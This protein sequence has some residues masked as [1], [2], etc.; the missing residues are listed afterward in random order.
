MHVIDDEMQ[1]VGAPSTLRA[2]WRLVKQWLDP[3]TLSKISILSPADMQQQQLLKYMP[4]TSIPREYGGTLDWKW[5]DKPLLDE[6]ARELAG[7]LYTH[8]K[9]AGG[10]GDFIEG[11]IIYSEGAIEVVGTVQRRRRED[12]I[13]TNV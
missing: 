6:P 8:H 7:G 5:G 1:I 9:N 3:E 4:L 12:I 10:I 13:S 2:A 11:P